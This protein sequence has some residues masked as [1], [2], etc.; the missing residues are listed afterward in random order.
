MMSMT[1][2]MAIGI[3]TLRIESECFVEIEFSELIRMN[4]L[5]LLYLTI[6]QVDSCHGGIYGPLT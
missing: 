1:D 3:E 4:P 5:M 2:P 6:N